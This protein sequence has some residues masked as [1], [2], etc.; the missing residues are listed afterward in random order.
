MSMFEQRLATSLSLRERKKLAKGA[1][2]R[3]DSE[4]KAARVAQETPEF[5]DPLSGG[6]IGFVGIGLAALVLIAL[7]ARRKRRGR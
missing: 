6:V 1:L 3:A 7:V 2:Q 5:V 4:R